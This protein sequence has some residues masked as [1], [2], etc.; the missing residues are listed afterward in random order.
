MTGDERI[1]DRPADRVLEEHQRDRDFINCVM[2][3]IKKPT[4]EL[5][6]MPHLRIPQLVHRDP[7]SSTPHGQL[8]VCALKGN[9]SEPFQR[10]SEHTQKAG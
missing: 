9:E 10:D 5:L 8:S 2:Y 4:C 3:S 6:G 1:A 7:Q